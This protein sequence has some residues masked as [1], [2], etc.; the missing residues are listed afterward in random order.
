MKRDSLHERSTIR[1]TLKPRISIENISLGSGADLSNDML[2]EYPELLR[3]KEARNRI[4][5]L[6]QNEDQCPIIFRLEDWEGE[7]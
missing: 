1:Q 2:F 4:S 3:E 5:V 6:S 7:D